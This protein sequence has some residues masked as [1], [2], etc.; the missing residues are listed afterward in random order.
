MPGGDRGGIKG[1]T[2]DDVLVQEGGDCDAANDVPKDET[3]MPLAEVHRLALPNYVARDMLVELCQSMGRP[4]ALQ[5]M[6]SDSYRL[7]DESID[8]QTLTDDVNTALANLGV[9]VRVYEIEVDDDDSDDDD[10]DDDGSDDDGSD[11]DEP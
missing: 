4:R 8:E 6:F 1:E 5:C 11:K 9:D 2:N 7:D 10:S 3:G